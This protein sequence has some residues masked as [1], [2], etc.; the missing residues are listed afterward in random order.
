VA[1]VKFGGSRQLQP[2]RAIR[3]GM[4]GTMEREPP[5]PW[6]VLI[7]WWC[8]QS[9]GGPNLWIQHS[10]RPK[11]FVLQCAV[12]GEFCLPRSLLH[13]LRTRW[14]RRR[15]HRPPRFR[16]IFVSRSSPTAVG[17]TAIDLATCGFRPIVRATGV[18]I[19]WVIG[20]IQ[21]IMAGTGSPM[22]RKPIG[23][24]LPTTTGTGIATPISVGRG[25]RTK[26]GP[27]LGSIGA[28]V[29]KMVSNM[30]AGRL[31]RPTRL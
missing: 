6:G 3:G 16:L 31:S 26:Y 15:S 23:A 19:R 28:T 9:R 25:S 27:R 21:T 17:A 7:R 4:R 30:S 14:A 20:S 18:P 29:C 11:C 24:G 13:L 10:R 22:I 1:V 5:G 2:L 12:A 8:S